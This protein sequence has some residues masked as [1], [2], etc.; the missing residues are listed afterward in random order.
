M[1]AG[2][3]EHST[4]A[5]WRSSPAIRTRISGAKAQKAK[6]KAVKTPNLAGCRACARALNEIENE[7]QSVRVTVIIVE[8][9]A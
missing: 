2:K 3:P 1:F 8:P 4:V 9:Q 5:F 6:S 7:K